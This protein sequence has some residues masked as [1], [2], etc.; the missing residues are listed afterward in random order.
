MFRIVST[1]VSAGAIILSIAII[2]LI[3]YLGRGSDT[4]PGSLIGWTT[5]LA[6]AAVA[7]GA[8]IIFHHISTILV[9]TMRVMRSIEEELQHRFAASRLVLHMGVNVLFLVSRP[10]HYMYRSNMLSFCCFLTGLMPLL[11]AMPVS[12]LLSLMLLWL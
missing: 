6:K 5:S 1:G 3:A 8:L 11:D 10:G 4:C 12:L 2:W 9:L 7:L